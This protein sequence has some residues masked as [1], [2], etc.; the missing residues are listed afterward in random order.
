MSKVTQQ[1]K[2]LVE[3]KGPEVES[4]SLKEMLD[5]SKNKYLIVN[6]VA[7]R[8]RDLNKGERSLLELPPPHTHTELAMAEAE[9]GLLHLV[10]KQKSKV[11]ISLIKN[12]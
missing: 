12:E 8:A 6:V 3:P 4:H 9:T 7:R 10:R 1:P 2:Y 11:L 5:L